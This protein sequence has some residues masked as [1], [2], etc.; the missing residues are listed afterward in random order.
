MP[1][2]KP[3]IIFICT[4]NSARS[5]LAESILRHEAGDRFN[6]FSAGTRPAAAPNPF[7]I[8]LLREKGHDTGGLRSKSLDEFQ[9][10]SAPEMD[11][12]FTVCDAA[13]NEEC[14]LWP[15]QPIS[16]HWGIADP[17]AVEGNDDAKRRAFATAYARMLARVRAFVALFAEGLDKA[18]LQKRIDQIG[19]MTKVD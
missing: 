19:T 18:A 8:A 11:F 9:L 2:D 1:P 7:A 6:A 15:G 16:G 12:I 17:A 3:N 14:P 5:I 4:G 10:D 13:A